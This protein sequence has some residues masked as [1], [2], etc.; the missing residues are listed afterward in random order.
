M[1]ESSIWT[2]TRLIII[3]LILFS[4]VLFLFDLGKRGL[5]AP[6]EP[7]YAQVAREMWVSKDFIL[8]HLNG[9]IYSQKPPLLF[10]LIILFS[11][12]FGDV[13][14]LSARLP[15]AL[16]G[17]GCVIATFS[18]GKRFVSN[19][20]GAI[21]ALILS[22]NA[23]FL[24]MSHRV[25][26]DVVLTFFI[27]MSLIYFLKGFSVET[28]PFCRPERSEGSPD[29][30]LRFAQNDKTIRIN[31][32]SKYFLL[33]YVFLALAVL[34]KGPVGFIPPFIAVLL[35]L[36]V[37]KKLHFLRKMELGKG[38]AIFFLI[39]FSWVIAASIKGGHDYMNEI[40]FKQNIGRFYDTWSHKR[41][42]YYFFINF[43]LD[44]LPWTFFL[45]GAFIYALL[46]KEKRREM[47]FPFLWFA[48]VFGFFTISTGKR[49]VY[50]LPLYPAA[51][52]MLAWF[53]NSFVGSPMDK[54]FRWIGY[55][56]GYALYGILIISCIILPLYTLKHFPGE[57]LSSLAIAITVAGGAVLAIVLLYLK[58]PLHALLTT[59]LF[60]LI[61]FSLAKE[62]VI[63]II[64]EEKSAEFICQKANEIMQPDDKLVIY[65]FFRPTYLYYTRRNQIELIHDVST[66][67]S[68]LASAKRV[69]LVIQEKH[70][71]EVTNELTAPV[72]ILEEDNVG[73]RE[74][75]LVSNQPETARHGY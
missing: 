62:L 7:T 3:I 34:T 66:L 2:K 25:A 27:T 10:W 29:E 36:A 64:N 9:E 39:V 57:F 37:Q 49:H 42:F 41:P 22:T 31:G 14:E 6:D 40:L 63:P 30:I 68:L 15:S 52:I 24:W 8:P 16:A 55:L 18:L 46:E 12:P 67:N 59:F 60:A 69:F 20:V 26:F 65:G 53:L 47:L 71:K 21:A 38:F 72:Y 11:L 70:F 44:F 33:F 19:K 73:H 58:R 23:L 1:N 50:I 28:H 32:R 5:W 13:T 43:P 74:I 61:T 56:P 48:A 4:S 75:L 54:R 51:S 45:P 17:I 35:Y